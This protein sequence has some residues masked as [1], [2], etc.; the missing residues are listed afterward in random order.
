LIQIANRVSKVNIGFTSRNYKL[1]AKQNMVGVSENRYPEIARRFQ[2]PQVQENQN[3]KI[4][5]GAICRATNPLSVG[6]QPAVR[7]MM[8]SFRA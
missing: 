8:R 4:P 5:N 6:G 7:G 3:R 2:M 1:F